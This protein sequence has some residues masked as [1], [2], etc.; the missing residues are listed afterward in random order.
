M[1][2]KNSHS[3]LKSQIGQDELNQSIELNEERNSEC[4]SE[5]QT[6]KLRC[7]NFE[8][9]FYFYLLVFIE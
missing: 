7:L 3:F 2:V 9:D 4:E 8:L 5:V 1:N 6:V